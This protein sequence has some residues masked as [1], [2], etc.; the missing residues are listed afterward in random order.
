MALFRFPSSVL[1]VLSLALAGLSLS[2]CGGGR[3]GETPDSPPRVSVSVPGASYAGITLPF[4]VTVTGCARVE[5]LSVFDGENFLKPLTYQEPSVSGE[6]AANEIPY[7]TGIAAKLSLT[8]KATCDDGREATSQP[9]PVSF[10]PVAQITP[11]PAGSTQT[12]TDVFNV[13]GGG[14]NTSFIGCTGN[15]NATASLVRVN[16]AGAELNRQ[17][18]M[19]V[20]CNNSTQYTDRNAVSKTRWAWTPSLGA[21]SL[22]DGLGITSFYQSPINFLGVGPDGDAVIYDDSRATIQRLPKTA[23][24]TTWQLSTFTQN[25]IV[26]GNPIVQSNGRVAL[27]Y[28]PYALGSQ[29]GPINVSVFDYATG[30]QQGTASLMTYAFGALTDPN[31]PP[32]FFNPA[33]TSLYVAV[34]TPDGN[35]IVYACNPYANGCDTSPQWKSAT[36]KGK[37]VTIVPFADGTRLA[38]VA[39]NYVWF[40]DA[41]SGT[42]LN[43]G[44]VGI[45]PTGSYVVQGVMAGKATDFYIL[46]GA[47]KQGALPVEVIMVDDPSRGELVRFETQESSLMLGVGDDGQAWLRLGNKL[48]KPLPLAQYRQVRP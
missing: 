13:E 31:P 25:T 46:T 41:A 33:G 8:A 42:V 26:L 30:V 39:S 11:P 38:A 18:A 21:M 40:L 27:A 16:L 22:D 5:A 37:I 6:L 20:G 15:A 3:A 44:G 4:S 14:A 36:L 23:N 1:S 17:D 34:R 9:Q 35:T 7:S 45:V 19:P 32:A 24:G 29:Q 48:V 12:V 2:G 47:N 43:K 10:L 28:F